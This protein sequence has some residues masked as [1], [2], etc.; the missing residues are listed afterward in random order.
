MA[1]V[2]VRERFWISAPRA[3]G[4]GNCA[5]TFLDFSAQ[6]GEENTTSIVHYGVKMRVPLGAPGLVFKPGSWVDA[7][8][9]GVGETA[10]LLR[11]GRSTFHH[12]QLLPAV[13]V[14]QER[15]GARCVCAGT[16]EASRR[17]GISTAW[18]RGDAGARTFAGER[19]AKR[20]TF[21]GVA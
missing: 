12:V 9:C 10:T 5:G 8:L 15:E 17:T 2:I 21:D 13:A 20:N 18:V 14:A 19:A 1:R 7:S 16:G 11:E 6:H 4:P 3:G